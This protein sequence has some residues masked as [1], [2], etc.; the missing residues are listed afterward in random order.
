M[1]PLTQMSNGRLES[2]PSYFA[3]SSGDKII[4]SFL[5]ILIDTGKPPE[6]SAVLQVNNARYTISQ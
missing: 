5:P 2:L 4:A 6:N 1:I 3:N